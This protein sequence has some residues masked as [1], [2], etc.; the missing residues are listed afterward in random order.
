MGIDCFAFGM[1]RDPEF[2]AER[3]KLIEER[4]RWRMKYELLNHKV[5]SVLAELTGEKEEE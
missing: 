4:D 2:N 1:T 3:A 5:D